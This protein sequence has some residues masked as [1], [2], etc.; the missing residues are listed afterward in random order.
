MLTE[1]QITK[2]LADELQFKTSRSG[3]KGGQNVNKVESKVELLFN[4]LE[5][6]AL[7][8]SQKQQLLQEHPQKLKD[9]NLHLKSEKDR[10]QLKNKAIVKK[11]LIHLLTL[12]LKP[13]KKRLAT[14]PG[15]AAK[16]KKLKHK[17]H[18]KEKKVLRQKIKHTY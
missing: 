6:E 9:G 15:K 8:A 7:T 4:L 14:K 1:N 13:K 5:S 12:W 16:E 2:I 10:S 17:K 18:L 11:Q 3:G